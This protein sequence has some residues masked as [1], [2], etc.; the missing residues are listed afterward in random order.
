[1]DIS[2][3]VL[4]FIC[5]GGVV[6]FVIQELSVLPDGIEVE[7]RQVA[8]M[9]AALRVP[10][11]NA[12]GGG[13]TSAVHIFPEEYLADPVL[14]RLLAGLTHVEEAFFLPPPPLFLPAGVIDVETGLQLARVDYRV[15]E[16]EHQ[17]GGG[18]LFGFIFQGRLYYD[19]HGFCHRCCFQ[20]C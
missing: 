1:M 15:S 13:G 11:P 14:P 18:I 6:V 12:S 4:W 19:F 10:F 9:V 2:H 17:E 20:I 8:G 3:G 5:G 7:G 16:W